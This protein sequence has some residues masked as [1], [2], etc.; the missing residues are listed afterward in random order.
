MDVTNSIDVANA[1]I[2]FTVLDFEHKIQLEFSATNSLTTQESQ[3]VVKVPFADLGS[4]G[5]I[6]IN[7]AQ[8]VANAAVLANVNRQC[9]AIGASDFE[10]F[11]AALTFGAG[12]AIGIDVNVTSKVVPNLQNVQLFMDNF[13]FCNLPPPNAPGCF[14]I[15]A[16]GTSV[17]NAGNTNNPNG[18]QGLVG[19][20]LAPTG[21]LLTAAQAVPTLDLPKIESYYSANATLPTNVNYT[22]LVEA[23]PLPTDIQAAVNKIIGNSKGNGGGGGGSKGGGQF[24]GPTGCSVLVVLATLTALARI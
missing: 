1:R 7:T 5:R 17:A 16:D 11:T 18:D 3:D 23:I 10:S 20:V 21:M 6:G 12:A 8:I 24:N 9:Q 19:L 2:N 4:D 14:I 13:T 22:Q 15:A